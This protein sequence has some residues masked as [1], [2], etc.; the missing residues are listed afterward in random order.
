MLKKTVITSMIVCLSVFLIPVLAFAGTGAE[1]HF[2]KDGDTEGWAPAGGERLN[3]FTAKGGYLTGTIVK[4]DPY[5]SLKEVGLD[6]DKYKYL[7]INLKNQT[8]SERVALF[9]GTSE[10]PGFHGSRRTLLQTEA[11]SN[12]FKQYVLDLSEIAAFKGTITDLRL[13]IPDFDKK[14]QGSFSV[15]YIVFSDTPEYSVKKA[16]KPAAS[17]PVNN[18]KTGDM[19]VMP[20]ILLAMIS[21]LMLVSAR[22]LRKQN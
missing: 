11:N 8:N 10:A 21:G 4:P 15:D 22:K 16:E 20:Y 12:E 1:W 18:P 14:E 17:Q 9:W 7:I 3:G 2:N 6:G 5:F 19:G 13:D